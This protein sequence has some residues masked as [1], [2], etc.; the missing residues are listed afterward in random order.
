MARISLAIVFVQAGIGLL[1]GSEVAFFAPA[2]LVNLVYGLAFAVSSLI[3]RPLAGTFASEM[4]DMP[5]EVRTS[6]TYR[7]VF[8]RISFVWGA[9]LVLRAVLRFALLVAVGVDA[10]V[11]TNLATGAPVMAVLMTWSVW[12]GT[13]GFRRSEEWGWAFA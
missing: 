8:G 2:V 11:A 1:S 4:V 12:Y 13:R 3:G 9:Y 5:D 10:F 7:Q 6:A